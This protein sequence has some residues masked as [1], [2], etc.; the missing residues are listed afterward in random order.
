MSCGGEVTQTVF[1]G[2]VEKYVE[3][4]EKV[5]L[6]KIKSRYLVE[7]I[8]LALENIMNVFEAE[9]KEQSSLEEF[10]GG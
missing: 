8:N 10:L 5:L 9:R 7:R 3:L 2:A 1:R 6:K 4:V